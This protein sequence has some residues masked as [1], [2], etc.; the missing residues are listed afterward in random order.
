M[1]QEFSREVLYSRLERC[2][3]LDDR[4][5]VSQVADGDAEAFAT[6]YDRHSARAYSLLL[7]ILN[8]KEEAEDALQE[9]FFDVWRL[10]ERFDPTLAGVGSWIQMIVRSRGI[11]RLRARVRRREK[12]DWTGEGGEAS[13]PHPTDEDMQQITTV[14]GSLTPDQRTAIW[15]A[16]CRGMSR[17]HIANVEDVPVGT[18]K[19]R[20][21]SGVARLKELTATE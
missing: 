10:A 8:D 17:Q 14:L 16:Y 13:P 20:I 19:S 4:D 12:T 2:M 1:T 18:I 15:M 6:L 11:D 21:R 7:M 5:I 9:A 3:G